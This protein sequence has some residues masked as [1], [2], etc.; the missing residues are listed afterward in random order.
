MSPRLVFDY[1]FDDVFRSL[2]GDFV[3]DILTLSY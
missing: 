1:V 2:S 3:P